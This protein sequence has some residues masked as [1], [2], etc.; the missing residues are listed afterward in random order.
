M[1][2][3]KLNNTR[4]IKDSR[5]ILFTGYDQL[6]FQFI[7]KCICIINQLSIISVIIKYENPV[8]I[9]GIHRNSL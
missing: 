1:I 7:I 3:R 9:I 2:I 5:D 6:Q 8:H 4:N